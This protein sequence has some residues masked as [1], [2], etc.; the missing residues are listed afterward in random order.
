M[1]KIIIQKLSKLAELIKMDSHPFISI[2]TPE[3]DKLK[4][5]VI[6]Y[7][8]G[9]QN[10]HENVSKKYLNKK[11]TSYLIEVKNQEIARS[12]E[13]FIDQTIKESVQKYESTEVFLPFSG[14]AI[15]SRRTI[16]DC[17]IE[18]YN[19]NLRQKIL[20]SVNSVIHTNK[21]YNDND[22]TR[23]NEEN[24]KHLLKADNFLVLRFAEAKERELV[25][26]HAQER[27]K[28]LLQL[29]NLICLLETDPKDGICFLPG[30]SKI[31]IASNK[32][33]ISSKTATYSIQ[34]FQKYILNLDTIWESETFI[35]LFDLYSNIFSLK[36]QV[37]PQTSIINSIIWASNANISFSFETK[38]LNLIIAIEALIPSQKGTSISNNI[39][40]SIAFI[41]GIDFDTRQN[42]Y[43]MMKNLY[44]KRS[45]LAHGSKISLGENDYEIAKYIYSELLYYFLLEKENFSNEKLFISLLQKKKFGK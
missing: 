11:L 22:K 44:D 17:E 34:T 38:I 19:T 27:L 21:N 40:E 28:A 35:K 3:K 41:L 12:A 1:K 36:Q 30:I 14:G 43:N 15:S 31:N 32:I 7:I 4:D 25:I 8:S 10:I 26:E 23:I 18:T 6:K 39:S 2:D 24:E 5:D 45:K 37:F 9:Q 33:D 16:L 29:L 20:E 42:Y 13:E